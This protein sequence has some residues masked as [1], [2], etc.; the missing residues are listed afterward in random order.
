MLLGLPVRSR[1]AP[2]S[3]GGPPLWGTEV[4]V[5]Q[6]P[7]PLLGVREVL[8][9]R[10]GQTDGEAGQQIWE[11]PAL[12]SRGRPGGWAIL[13][14]PAF[15]SRVQP[16]S[17]ILILWGRGS[18][19]GRCRDQRLL[20]LGIEAGLSLRPQASGLDPVASRALG[21]HLHGFLFPR[22][23]PQPQRTAPALV[24]HL[25]LSLPTRAADPP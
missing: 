25:M 15:L 16:G 12:G 7:S 10:T 13:L 20:F 9:S 8:C 2:A 3:D 21:T 14:F 17:R 23:T 24:S 6:V 1:G 11:W 18:G 4:P 22:D 5:T 19:P